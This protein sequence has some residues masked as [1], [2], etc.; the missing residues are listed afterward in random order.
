MEKVQ[1]S[2]DPNAILDVNAKTTEKIRETLWLRMKAAEIIRKIDVPT[3]KYLP[4]LPREQ[5]GPRCQQSP[6]L[7]RLPEGYYP[8]SSSLPP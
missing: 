4:G 1:Y 7:F 8:Q 2:I 6:F 5:V 3:T